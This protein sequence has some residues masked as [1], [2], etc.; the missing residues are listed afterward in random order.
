MEQQNDEKVLDFYNACTDL[1]NAKLLLADAKIGKILKC[2][3]A[4]S[5]LFAAV[6]EC[7]V[8]FNFETEFRKAQVQRESK[9]LYFALPSDRSK[10]VALVFNILSSCDTHQLDLHALIRDFFTNDSDDMSYGFLN[11]VHKIVFPFRDALCSMVGFGD[12]E[13]E[14]VED[15]EEETCEVCEDDECEIDEE[16]LLG[17]FFSDVSTILSRIREVVKDDPKTKQDRKEEILITLDAL[18]QTIDLGNLKIMNALLISLYY[19][20]ANVK[21]VRFY[22]TELEERFAKFYS[23]LED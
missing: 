11:F 21:S 7:L 18:F 16:D 1:Q 9:N 12:D 2:I 8:N 19:L 4:S 20:L 14:P 6:G 17:N 22:K 23:Q 3:T 5:E 10:L 13:Q 15:E